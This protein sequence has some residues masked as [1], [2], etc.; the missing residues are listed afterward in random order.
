MDSGVP[1]S[2]SIDIQANLELHF[3]HMSICL[4]HDALYNYANF[5]LNAVVTFFQP[6]F[7]DEDFFPLTVLAMT[8]GEINYVDTF[9]SSDNNPFTIDAYIII[10]LFMIVM[11]IAVINLLVSL[12]VEE[13]FISKSQFRNQLC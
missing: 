8:L 3:L 4:S 13:S 9:V 5:F 2:D 7:R 11:P 10:T 6:G 1:R 12:R